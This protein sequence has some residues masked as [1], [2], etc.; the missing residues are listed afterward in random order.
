MIIAYRMAER[1][2]GKLSPT[3]VVKIH[4]LH[5]EANDGKVLFTTNAKFPTKENREKINEIILMTKDGSYAV[6]A[7]ID[8]LGIFE[9]Q[10][11]PQGYM[12]PSVWNDETKKD[13]GWFALRNVKEITIHRG[14]FVSLSG[15]DL[16]D[17]MNGDASMVYLDKQNLSF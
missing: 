7:N 12:V 9:N 4:F 15:K 8:G 6:M 1:C 11:P 10:Q 14:D 5:A 3:E 2:D 17:S 16:L 13:R